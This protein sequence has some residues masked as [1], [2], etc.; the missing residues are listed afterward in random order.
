M[1]SQRNRR[2]TQ[3]EFFDPYAQTVKEDNQVSAQVVT[4]FHKNADT[5][6]GKLSAHHTIGPGPH[7][8]A[9][10][11]HVHDGGETPQLGAGITITGS[12]GG[13]AALASVISALVAIL[14][15]TDN[16]T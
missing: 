7:Q 1:V 6:V 15:V 12:K 4:Q 2:T 14:G 9:S 11:K 10:G 13:N 8:A 16:T 5:D 3:V